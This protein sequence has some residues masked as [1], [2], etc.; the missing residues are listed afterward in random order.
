MNIRLKPLLGGI[1]THIVPSVADAMARR[2]QPQVSAE[3][4]YTVWMRHVC[5]AAFF[6]CWNEPKT[7]LELGPGTT[8]GT[9]IAA[10]LSGV[11]QY[12]AAEIRP[13]PPL[14]FDHQVFE[15][16]VTLFR[17]RK[18][19]AESDRIL[20]STMFPDE[21]FPHEQF[22]QTLSNLDRIKSSLQSQSD[23]IRMLPLPTYKCH[24]VVNYLF[25]HSVLE[26]ISELPGAYFEMFRWLRPGGVMTHSIDFSSHGTSH[27]WNGHWTIPDF[28]WR[29]MRGK[30]RYFLNRE[31]ASVHRMW[32]ERVGFEIIAFHPTPLPSTI[33]KK[34]LT[35]RFR[36][37]TESDLNTVSAFVVARKP[38]KTCL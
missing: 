13:I 8:F 17:E 33:T 20:P 3:Y 28:A 25:S 22:A 29:V 38:F 11:Q 37:L 2:N 24:G 30:R 21:L 6:Q 5:T 12:I 7:V 9:G 14:H 35:K 26:H 31:P 23:M 4:Y 10:L 34:D 36:N 19:F 32:L 1:V 27:F 18:P 16:L 15:E